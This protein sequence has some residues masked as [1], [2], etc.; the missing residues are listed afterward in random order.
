MK[1]DW[2]FGA[3]G[4]FV[5]GFFGMG[6]G[7][8]TLYPLQKKMDDKKKANATCLFIILPLTLISIGIYLWNGSIDWGLSLKVC[9]GGIAGAVLGA[10]L[11]NKINYKYVLWV[12]CAIT[13]AGGITMIFKR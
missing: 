8:V 5:N 2:L 11:L 6:G 10:F 13:V 9:G 3:I 12:Y 7:T 1:K 4:G